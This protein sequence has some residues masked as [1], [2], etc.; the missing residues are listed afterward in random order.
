MNHEIKIG[1]VYMTEL[2]MKFISK[3]VYY[4]IADKYV[5]VPSEEEAHEGVQSETW[6]ALAYLDGQKPKYFSDKYPDHTF[7]T[8]L[9]KGKA[10]LVHRP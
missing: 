4:V 6:Y 7:Q 3:D 8:L 1:D 5:Y 10:R 2:R 9:D